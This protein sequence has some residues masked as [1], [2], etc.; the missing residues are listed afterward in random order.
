MGKVK[1]GWVDISTDQLVKADWN[2]KTEDAA[3]SEKLKANIKR[4]GQIENIIIRELPTGFYEVVNGNHRY[5]VLKDLG[6]ETIHAFNLGTIDDKKAQRIAIETNETK[7]AT[8]TL[9]LAELLHELSKEFSTDDLLETLPYTQ[10]Q[11]ADF[12]KMLNL[13]WDEF[14]SNSS[15]TSSD[16][17]QEGGYQQLKLSI[18]NETFNAWLKLK[19][20]MKDLLGM[21]SDEK[22]FEYAIIE[23]LNIP[24]ESIK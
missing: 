17:E 1:H 4:N 19:E 22:V 5:D 10:E 20:R 3:K 12:D 23:A 7:F 9:Q 11:L 16:T 8:D 2:Y 13:D 24:D 21:E 6:I 14:S 15:D 18:P